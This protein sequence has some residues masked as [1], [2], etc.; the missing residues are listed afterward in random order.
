[1]DND[2]LRP[3]LN[4]L[5][6]CVSGELRTR[7]TDLLNRYDAY[8]AAV[9]APVGVSPSV[10]ALWAAGAVRFADEADDILACHGK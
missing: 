9:Q 6:S 4:A 2:P 10:L 3:T 5:V 1:M 8:A 7:A